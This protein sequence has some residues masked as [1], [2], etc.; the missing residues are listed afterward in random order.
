ML[1]AV[2][3]IVAAPGPAPKEFYDYLG[4]KEPAYSVTVRPQGSS[5]AIEMTS[6]TWQGINWKHEILYN[7]PRSVVKK[8]VAILYI[9]GDGPRPAD[10]ADL[11]LI[12]AATKLPVAT[13][14]DVPNQPLFG[15]LKE[16]DL[17]AH[18]FTRYLETGDA[19][20]P[21]LFPMAKSAI[22]AMDA[23][24]TTPADVGSLGIPSK[25]CVPAAPWYRR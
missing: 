6:Q 16:D 3:A 14:F 9:T 22:K 20:W 19:T 13:L 1:T 11:A 5:M 24:L 25:R 15:S 21:L 10:M 4:R 23:V 8:G 12:V 17:I 2:L 18:T 7:T